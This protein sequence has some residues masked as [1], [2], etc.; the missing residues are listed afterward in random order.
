[1]I[2]DLWSKESIVEFV[3]EGFVFCYYTRGQNNARQHEITYPI[4]AF[5]YLAI[6]D[7]LTFVYF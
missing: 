3:N 4:S 5:P 6:I 7:P 1:M 2:R